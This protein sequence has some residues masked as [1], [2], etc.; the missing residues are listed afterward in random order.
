MEVGKLWIKLGLDKSEFEKDVGNVKK[1]GQ[2]LGGFL[3]NAFSTTLGIG[4]FDAINTGMRTAW[5][6]AIG[7]D[8]ALQQNTIAFETMLG[9]AE[10]ASVLLGDLAKFAESTPFEFTDLASASKKMLAFGFSAEDVIPML[11]SVGDASAGLGMSGEEGVGRIIT[12]L[13]QMKAKAKVSGGEMMQLTE[14]GIPAWQILAEKM[15]ISTAEVMKLSEQ[16]LIPADEA[17]QHLI[18]GMGEKFPDMMAKQSQTYAGLMSTLKDT[19]ESTLGAIVKPAFDNLSN[20]VLPKAIEMVTK[21]SDAFKMDGLQGILQVIFPPEMV[22][23]INNISVVV[24]GLS[25]KFKALFSGVGSGG[26][27]WDSINSVFKFINDNGSVIVGIISSL[28]G[29]FV[30]LKIATLAST[31][32]LKAHNIVLALEAI[33]TGNS[34][35]MLAVSENLKGKNTIAQW[36]LNTAMSLNPIVIVVLAIGALVGA[37]VYLWNTNEG[38]RNALIGAWDAIKGFFAGIPEWFNGVTTAIGNF[39]SALGARI[40]EIWNGIVNYFTGIWTTISNIFTVAV[41]SVK[42]IVDGVMTLIFTG[43]KLVWNGIV[44]YYTTIWNIISGI[45]VWVWGFIGDFV[46]TAVNGIRDF[47]VTIFTGIADF[48]TAIWT[49]ISTTV[50]TITTAIWNWIVTVFTSIW[51]SIV[52]IWTGVSTF[53]TTIFTAIHKTVSDAITAVWT[54]I[55]SVFTSIY[56]TIQSV[57]TAIHNTVSSIWNTIKTTI[58]TVV[59][60]IRTTVSNTFES[61]KTKVIGVVDSLKTSVTEKFNAIRDAITKP[62][63]KAKE[64]VGE[65]VDDIKGF[66]SGLEL[67]EIKIPKIK[68][69]HF[70]LKGSFSLAPPS[71]PSFAVDWYKKGGIFNSP[72][73]IGV[74][75]AGSEVVLP[76][77]KL[78]SI[79][80]DTLDKMQGVAE[81]VTTNGVIIKIDN[82]T[83]RNDRDIEQISE[84]LYKKME[85]NSRSKGV[86]L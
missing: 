54:V 22:D 67:P 1:E 9:S 73:V 48:F 11:T 26:S 75:E 78:S 34:N 47:F 58:A 76:I 13:G 55:K 17:I 19:T 72:S 16:G 20:N 10:K 14:A 50:Y 45:F 27:A 56:G 36:L 35:I 25:E 42:A 79:L 43:I 60:S 83:V 59:E 77:S 8:S 63:D 31:L 32:A 37:L 61:I 12:A 28:A 52:Q 51:D 39:F 64:L 66:F 23:T 65:A 5:D 82:M 33:A 6:M 46:M 84:L 81:P 44:W 21:I 53:F 24:E 29:G 2:G 30:A 57:L 74:G 7:Y 49:A 86:R 62:V 40:A 70:S 68:L 69:P 3:K 80:A 85:G 18:A 4:M 38:F 41:M 71:V 15:N